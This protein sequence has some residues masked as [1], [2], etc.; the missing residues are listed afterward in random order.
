MRGPRSDAYD[1]FILACEEAG[2]ESLTLEPLA[3]AL[4]PRLPFRERLKDLDP[5]YSPTLSDEELRA[6]YA[7]HGFEAKTGNLMSLKC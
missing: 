7:P 5:D 4:T 6:F 1:R 2:V 3:F